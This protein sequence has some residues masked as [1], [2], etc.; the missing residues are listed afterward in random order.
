MSVPEMAE[1]WQGHRRSLEVLIKT[2][3]ALVLSWLSRLMELL[4]F[5]YTKLL[6]VASCLG[7]GIR[8]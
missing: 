7:G 5:D 3:T 6:I 8:S 2:I 4:D 1:G